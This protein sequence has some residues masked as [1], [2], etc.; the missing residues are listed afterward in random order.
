MGFPDAESLYEEFEN[1]VEDIKDKCPECSQGELNQHIQ[2]ALNEIDEAFEAWLNGDDTT[3]LAD[4][5]E[6]EQDGEAAIQDY[7]KA[8]GQKFVPR[9]LGQRFRFAEVERPRGL[10]EKKRIF[11]ERHRDLAERHRDL[12]E[13]HRDLAERRRGLAERRKGLAERHRD[14]AERHRDL[15]EKHPGSKAQGAFDTIASAA[16]GTNSN[17]NSAKSLWSSYK[18]SKWAQKWFGGHSL[19]EKATAADAQAWIQGHMNDLNDAANK[20]SAV[21]V[22]EQAN[23]D[24]CDDNEVKQDEQ[25]AE[26]DFEKAESEFNESD[27]ESA[28]EDIE[29]AMAKANAAYAKLQSDETA[30]RKPK[31]LASRKGFFHLA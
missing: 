18:P 26:Q 25:E 24:G 4:A 17:F 20:W 19:A 21:A 13:R 2:A 15:A 31:K 11:A 7:E 1:T 23:C 12:A 14:L 8:S 30:P 3:A 5:K 29:A 9:S 10:A 27:Y 6:A 28:E 22:A 16:A